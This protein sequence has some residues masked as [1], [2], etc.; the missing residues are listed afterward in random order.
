MKITYI[1]DPR[2]TNKRLLIRIEDKGILV[3]LKLFPHEADTKKVMSIVDFIKE[4]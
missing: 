1:G 2:D 4:F 3:E